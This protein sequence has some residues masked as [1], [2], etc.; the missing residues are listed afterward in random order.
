MDCVDCVKCKVYG[1]MQV[2]GLG[3]AL[4]SFLKEEI[5]MLSRNELV[6]FI[7]TLNK[8]TEALEIL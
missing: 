7:N 5:T 2:L 4:R 8:W 6:A 3:V 1:K